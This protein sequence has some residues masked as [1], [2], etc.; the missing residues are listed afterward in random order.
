MQLTFLG[1]SAGAPTK[2]RNVTGVAL[3]QGGSWDLFDCGEA[4]QHQLLSTP[5]SLPKLNRIFI[6]H[7]HGDHCFGIF[8]ENDR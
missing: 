1:T 8:G 5:L 3:K 7:L 4:T 6:S 2:D